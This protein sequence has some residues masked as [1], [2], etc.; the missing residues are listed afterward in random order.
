MMILAL[1]SSETVRNETVRRAGRRHACQVED[2]DEDE[3]RPDELTLARIDREREDLPAAR[4]D[5]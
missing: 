1:V 3:G 4:Q 2:E 5:P